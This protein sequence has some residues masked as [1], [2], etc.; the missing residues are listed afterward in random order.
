MRLLRGISSNLF[1]YRNYGLIG[2]ASY[3]LDRFY[4]FDVGLSWLNIRSE[5][6][7]DI[8][9]KP[10]VG[11]FIVPSA[12]FVHDNILWGYT[13]PI[14]GTR[15]RFDVLGNLGINNARQ[16]FISFLGDYRTYFRF[17]TDHSLAIRLSGGI[18]EGKNP[19]RFFIGGVDYWINRTYATT[20]V[21]IESASDFAFLT[22]ALPLRGYNYAEQIGTRYAL[23]NIELRFPLIRYLLTGGLPLLFSNIQG[24][25]FIDAGSAWSKSNKLQLFKKDEN[26]KLVTDDLLVGTGAGAR[27]FFLYFLLRFDVAWAYNIEGF[28]KPKFYFSL[29]ADF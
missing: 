19:Q 4:R 5:N 14:Q 28:S 11:S 26:N 6:L 17:F 23:M 22:A 20:E 1:R 2:I 10:D 27:I 18:S 13:S 16:R 7:D 25:L 29:G 12:S 3:P 15:Y 21:P 24:V 8:S 9:E